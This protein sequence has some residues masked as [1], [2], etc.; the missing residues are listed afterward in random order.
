MNRLVLIAILAALAAAAQ[1]PA[2][3]G[4]I[5]GT[6]MSEE[7]QPIAGAT[8]LYARTLA[9]KPRVQGEAPYQLAPGET[10]VSSSVTT[11]SAGIF[12]ADRLPAGTYLVCAEAYDQRFLNPCKWSA[13]YSAAVTGGGAV[14]LPVVM[15]SGVFLTVHVNDPKVLLP[16]AAASP[17]DFPHLIVGVVYGEGGF[18]AADTIS[19]DSGGRDFRM[20]IRAGTPLKLWLQSRYVTLADANSAPVDNNGARIPFQG[21][22]G[23]DLAFTF[24]VSGAVQ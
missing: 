7:G 23:T 21:A 8:V 24:Q 12:L 9:F 11:D 3:T 1:T 16:R 2:Q 6:V 15:Q 13:A 22:A 10:V 5:Q 20:P 18:L 4:A 19:I 17:L 14:T